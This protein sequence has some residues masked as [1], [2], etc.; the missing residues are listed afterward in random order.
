[1]SD[2]AHKNKSQI[3]RRKFLAGLAAGTTA[4]ALSGR[5]ADGYIIEEYFRQHF[6]RLSKDDL[7][8]ILADLEEELSFEYGKKA[9]VKATPPMDNVVFGYALDLS[10]CIGC[11]RCVYGCVN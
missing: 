5:N 8:K 3:T 2:N 7:K 4:L 1:M 11:R 6:K 10:R 9:T